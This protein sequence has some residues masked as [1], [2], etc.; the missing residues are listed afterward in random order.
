VVSCGDDRPPHIGFLL[1]WTQ[2]AGA[3]ASCACV[4]SRQISIG[5]SLPPLWPSDLFFGT[6]YSNAIFSCTVHVH[7]CVPFLMRC[8]RELI[9]TT[10][11]LLS[12]QIHFHR[13]QFA[14]KRVRLCSSSALPRICTSLCG[15][16]VTGAK[17]RSQARQFDG[18]TTLTPNS[19]LP[20]RSGHN[21][22]GSP[23][24]GFI[25]T[26]QELFFVKLLPT[27]EIGTQLTW[28]THWGTCNN[29]SGVACFCARADYRWEGVCC[30]L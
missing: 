27:S 14:Y 1:F 29:R 17:W 26:G 23:T 24:G 10:S 30:W 2:E 13:F 11:I 8:S 6:A 25:T 7:L 21:W 4:W 22:H 3:T 18:G 5:S 19:C 20:V 15:P 16:Q 28:L 12:T 9:C